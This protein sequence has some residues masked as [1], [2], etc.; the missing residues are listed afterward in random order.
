MFVKKDRG[1]HRQL[2]N[3]ITGGE[4][5]PASIFKIYP[6][7]KSIPDIIKMPLSTEYIYFQGSEIRSKEMVRALR[8][9][10]QTFIDIRCFLIY[11]KNLYRQDQSDWN[12]HYKA[13][14][15]P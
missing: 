9:I 8:K 4:V 10:D 12:E 7:E 13:Q 5:K 3:P 15:P 1:E 14:Y 2:I 11:L 6:E